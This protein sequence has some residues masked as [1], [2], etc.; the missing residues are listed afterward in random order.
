LGFNIRSGRVEQHA[1]QSGSGHEFMEQL[2]ALWLKRVTEK[3]NARHIA[4][5]P[6]ETSDK[7]KLDG[8]AAVHEHN[9]DYRG[10]RF[11][12]QRSRRAK[13]SNHCRERGQPIVLT[14]C[15]PIFNREV[16]AFNITSFFESLPKRG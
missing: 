5:R 2:Q 11:G 7:A 16:L 3:V 8:V 13:R 9:R 14:F 4:A 1:N 6:I 15:P 12:R 10:R